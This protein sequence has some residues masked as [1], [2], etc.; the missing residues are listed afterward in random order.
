MKS[1]NETVLAALRKK[2]L[3]TGEITRMG[4]GRPAARIQDLRDRDYN[5]VTKTIEVNT[6]W[7]KSRVA[8][9]TLKRKTNKQ[10]VKKAA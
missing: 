10:A 5:I 8:K 1:Q 7:G 9:Y 4:I 6:M 3:T 2:S